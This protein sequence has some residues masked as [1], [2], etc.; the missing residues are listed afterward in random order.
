MDVKK[1]IGT[2]LIFAFILVGCGGVK[3][4]VAVEE[5]PKYKDGVDYPIVLSVTAGDEAVTGLE[6]VAT[7]EMARMDHG[8]IEVEFSDQGDGTYVGEVALPMAGEW[9][10]DVVVTQDGDTFDE[11]LTFDVDEE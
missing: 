9:I 2:L 7:L 10:A 11:T 5:A 4:D 8:I 3:M 1:A 6:V